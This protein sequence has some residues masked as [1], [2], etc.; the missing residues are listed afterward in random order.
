[1]KQ[2][3][4]IKMKR[5]KWTKEKIIQEAKKYTS[6]GEF[7]KGNPNAYSASRRLECIDQACAHMDHQHESW[8]EE[9]LI[10]AAKPYTSRSEFKKEK[11][12]RL[13]CC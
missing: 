4:R 7:K 6:R 5:T 13:C 9:K 1:M 12:G 2:S 3:K 8:T 10:A 11:L